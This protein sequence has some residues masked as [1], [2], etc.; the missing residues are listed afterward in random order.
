MLADVKCSMGSPAT[1]SPVSFSSHTSTARSSSTLASKGPV[2][3]AAAG[4]VG[5][6]QKKAG[7]DVL[8][9]QHVAPPPGAGEHVAYVAW[10]T[11]KVVDA[12]MTPDG[13]MTVTA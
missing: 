2:G 4:T 3:G 6:S 8:F 11:P 13:L 5:G 9:P 10:L 12:R 1:Q 7:S